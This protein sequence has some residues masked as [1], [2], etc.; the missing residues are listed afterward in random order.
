MRQHA[1]KIGLGFAGLVFSGYTLAQGAGGTIGDLNKKEEP[2][3]AIIKPEK[4]PEA[5]H[6]AQIDTEKFEAGVFL[7]VMN[8]EDF[9][10][11]PSLGFSFSYHVTPDILAQVHYGNSKV[12][13]AS[14]EELED[15]DFLADDDRNFRYT[16]LLGGYRVLRGRSFFSTNT[17]LFSDIYLL[18]GLGQTSF[19]DNSSTS[20]VLAASY[21][22]VVTDWMTIN[23]DIRDHIMSREFIGDDKTTHNTE[24]V[25]GFNA[26]F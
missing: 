4:E 15:A 14:F 22:T 1:L 8:V 9:N 16:E 6:A 23:V 25:I 11:N 13:R 7:G 21:R 12:S 19:A 17:K 18:G 10:S 5:V 2:E 20:F 26:L 24:L 3:K